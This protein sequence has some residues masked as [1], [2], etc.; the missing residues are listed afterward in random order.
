M[1]LLDYKS[2]N[3]KK[4]VKEIAFMGLMVLV[5][6]NV[7]S[8]L[9]KPELVDTQLPK[10]N[11]RLI[12]GEVFSTLKPT[13]RPLLIHFWATWCPICQAEADNLQRLS[14]HFDVVTIAVKSGSDEALQSYM[15]ERG[16]DYRVI[17]DVNGKWAEAFDIAAYPTTFIY[18]G[19]GEISF[20]EV[21]YTSSLGLLFRMWWAGL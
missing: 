20:S 18:D 15:D 4:I 19:S 8:Y 21:G 1:K 17:N 6:S 2:W 9:R 3:V 5:I 13:G 7:L 16:F 10:I 11:E 12:N 14:N